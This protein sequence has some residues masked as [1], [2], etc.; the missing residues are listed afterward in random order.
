MYR[1]LCYC[2]VHTDVIIFV[3][4]PHLHSPRERVR[5]GNHPISKADFVTIWVEVQQFFEKEEAGADPPEWALFFDR[6]FALA[7]LYFIRKK[8]E[9]IILEVGIGGRYDTTNVFAHPVACVI[10]SVSLDHQ[11]ILGN[12]LDKIAWQKAG[13]MKEG[14][15]C[16][17]SSQQL[18][19]VK[20]VLEEEARAVNCPLVYASDGNV[21][22][23]AFGA[24]PCQQENA[25]LAAA[26]MR[27][28]G[29]RAKGFE[30]A[31]L[32]GRFEVLV[33]P[34]TKNRITVLLDV[35]HNPASVS[36]LFES[37]KER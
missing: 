21:M 19:T 2:L 22:K 28:I 8:V 15:P 23:P 11:D 5:L 17:T 34:G 24:E 37:V 31:Y 18:S 16:I 20:E 1:L 32:P 30:S 4:S 13:I 36:K 6:I 35:A 9:Y 10:T 29:F 25:R 7:L 26:V 3:Y 33:V 27:S 14:V 12:T